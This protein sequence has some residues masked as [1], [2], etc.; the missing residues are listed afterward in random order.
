MAESEEN[1]TP[2]EGKMKKWKKWA[3]AVGAVAC[4][5]A[6][7]GLGWLGMWLSL[8]K[9]TRA[10]LWAVKTAEN[11]YYQDI[12][13]D[14]IYGGFFDSFTDTLD[15]YSGYY[16]KKEYGEVLDRNAGKSAGYGF[17]VYEEGSTAH[18]FLYSVTGNSPA[19]RAGLR[20]GMYIF[21]IGE[22][23][24]TLKAASKEGITALLDGAEGP[25]VFRCGYARDGSDAKNYTFEYAEYRVSYCLY[26]DMGGSYRFDP[27]DLSKKIDL[28]DPLAG[29]D[30]DT[31]YIRFDR[32]YG[33]APEEFAACLALMKERGRKN[34]IIDLRGNGGGYL[35]DFCEIASHLL[36][37]AEEERPVVAKARYRDGGEYI[38]RAPRNDYD[39][40]FSEESEVYVIANEST[41]S[42][43]E[44]LIGALV[45]YG[46]LPYDHIFLRANGGKA[47]TYGKGIMQSTYTDSAGNA[48]K[49]TVAELFWPNGTSIHGKG[50][51]EADGA[52]PLSGGTIFVEEDGILREVLG[53]VSQTVG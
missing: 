36:K 15:P 34:L 51:T 50:V 23:E 53:V 3:I 41:A 18:P 11:N 28:G 44:C 33:T 10:L 9:N 35:D 6:L 2:K 25:V 43:S 17:S 40:Y 47:R 49:L 12:T 42:A 30:M 14:D 39:K 7:F 5:L 46:T 24:E 37:D 20:N 1:V 8:G 48:L 4:A 52:I 26:R 16:P 13:E 21:A 32:F 22:S 45:S 27:T 29:A 38:Y 19:E 31:A